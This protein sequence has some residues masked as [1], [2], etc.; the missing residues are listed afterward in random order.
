[1]L[2]APQQQQQRRTTNSSLTTTTRRG[3]VVGRP[4]VATAAAA[5]VPEVYKEGP[6]PELTAYQ[7]HQKTAAR[8]TP[9]ADARTLMTLAKCVA[10]KHSGLLRG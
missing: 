1:M 2:V 8:P 10:C 7:E 3:L 4:L 9:A 5:A 6:D